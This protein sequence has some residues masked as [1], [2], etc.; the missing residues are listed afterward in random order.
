MEELVGTPLDRYEI[1]ELLGAGGMGAVYK[2]RDV[3]LQRDVA[4]KVLHRHIALQADFEARFLQEAR[5]AARLDNP[6]IVQIYDFGQAHD[7][8][9][10][11]M[12][13]IAG[14]NLRQML[15]GLKETGKWVPLDEGIQL[16]RQV[17]LTLDYAHRRGVLHRD[18]KP[19]NIMIEPEPSEDLPYRPVITD[20]GLAKLAEGGIVTMQGSS[21]GTP[22]YMSPEQAL[23]QKTDARSDVYSLGILLY[24]LSVGRVPFPA[25]TITEAIRYH[26]TETP[27]PPRSIRPDLPQS[28]ERIILQTLEKDPANRFSD[29]AA[30]AKA[31]EGVTS[32]V[33]EVA[34]EPTVRENAVSLITQ[35]MQS[36]DK[37]RGA[38]ILREFDTPADFSQDS[39]HILVQG[40]TVGSVV[41]T[42]ARTTIGR[43]EDNDIVLEDPRASR[44]HARV[45]FT[46]TE[47][48]IVDL[49][50]RN[51]TFLANTKL[52]PGMSEVWTPDEA[53]R[54]G[55]TWLHL[56]RAQEPVSEAKFHYDG[57]VVDSRE[58][59]TSPGQGWVGI[60]LEKTQL[61]VEPGGSTQATVSV[62][63]QGPLVDHFQVS[64][65]GVPSD[66]VSI[67]PSVIH[68]LPGQQQAVMLAIHPPKSPGSRAGQHS[69][70][71]RVSS[72]NDPKQIAQ[73][74]VILTVAAYHQYNLNIRP[75][76][77]SG[78]I[79]G[80]YTLQVGNHC[81]TGLTL[82]FDA[83]DIED[84]CRYTFDP[85]QMVVAAG[86]E[87]RGQLKVRPKAP[88][89]G[90][91]ARTYSF[92]VTAR[93]TEV[94]WL[95]QQ[96]QGMWVQIPPAYS[97]LLRPLTQSGMTSGAFTVQVTNLGQTELTVQLEAMD[98]E[99]G[100]QVNLNPSQITVPVGQA[101]VVQLDV[102]PTTPLSTVEARTYP[103]TVTVQPVEVPGFI[104]QVHGE[105]VHTPPVLDLT[106]HKQ[107][108]SGVA[109]GIFSVH[110]SNRSAAAVT[111]QWEATSQDAD[112]RYTFEPSRSTVPAGGEHRV[113]LKISSKTPPPMNTTQTHA[114]TVS[115]RLVE[116]PRLIW[117]THGEWVRNAP[118]QQIKQITLSQGAPPS[119]PK[120][121][122]FWGCV[123]MVIG[124]VITIAFGL[125]V[126]NIAFEVFDLGDTETWIVAIIA[127]IVGVILTR[128]LARK[129][130]KG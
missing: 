125:L 43:K 76:K 2:A 29:A 98:T 5:S 33:T 78:L 128:G 96:A 48:R 90:E 95:Q 3:T 54:I 11:V 8:L 1:L 46:G 68:L 20:L 28:L 107:E 111:V 94:Q 16:V 118:P 124:V 83:I 15:E 21:M 89:R 63:N 55:S 121:R 66:W 70:T 64:V 45:E 97:V 22:A 14:A 36:L 4:I 127:W 10:I 32:A 17:S 51:G 44:Y 71:I 79:E 80:T 75:R 81:N 30:L 115:A 65:H 126:G 57:S 58:V 41:I 123:I 109:Q 60:L 38:S 106:L 52:L 120:P 108:Q 19:Q 37:P 27:P 18:I 101:Q 92:T 24:E 59:Q 40:K 47:Y 88:L 56:V 105:W 67:P 84:G 86:Q 34:T 25:K 102:L 103:F 26:T 42:N 62:L 73:I 104:Q 13:L 116:A 7:R 87:Q 100:C 53:L 50:S 35:Y 130:M 85:P 110:I 61:A 6:G 122:R 114:F 113:Q 112:C 31:L 91:A 39:I 99:G 129:V 69:L 72:Q 23:G 93:P 82:Q 49:D 77:Q 12:K 117:K 119:T 9:Y 74:D